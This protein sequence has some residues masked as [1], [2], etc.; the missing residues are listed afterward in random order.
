M[1]AIDVQPPAIRRARDSVR[2][3]GTGRPLTQTGRLRLADAIELAE[4]LDTD[5]RVQEAVRSSGELYHLGLLLAWFK[6]AGLV[7]TVRGRLVVVRRHA[8]LVDRPA[9]LVT[10]LLDALPKLGEEFG[11]SVV[12]HD[13]EHTVAAVLE[14]LVAA[15]GALAFEDAAEVAWNVATR[16][17]WFPNATELQLQT[18]RRM[19]HYDVRRMLAAVTDLGLLTLG[20]DA[21][22]LTET[23]EHAIRGWLG[24]GSAECQALRVR[25]TLEESDPVVWRRLVVP[26]DIR[27]D[28]FHQAI[29]DAMG[30]QDYHLH[31]FERGDE[32]WGQVL[33]DLDFGDERSATLG[34]LLRVE[35]DRLMYEYDFGDGWR[36]DVTLEAIVPST[37]R[38]RCLDGG[39]RCPPEDVGGI[40]GYEHLRAVLADPRDPEH[41][42]MLAWLGIEDARSF[43][44]TAFDAADAALRC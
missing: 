3:V 21:A 39:G 4:E 8:V 12:G 37:D 18:Q 28:R 29:A 14:A 42:D 40:S 25:V 10:R 24:M 34:A 35:G 15:H 26:A 32:R 38:S 36:H 2:W 5:D 23:G 33:E 30:W 19:A 7:R 43:D 27:L 13:A 16:R 22:T 1:N 31:C 6:A 41:D 17:Y 44:P 9:Q 20:Q 11:D